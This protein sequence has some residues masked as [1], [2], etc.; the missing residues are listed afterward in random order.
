MRRGNIVAQKQGD[1]FYVLRLADKNVFLQADIGKLLIPHL[2]SLLKD[3]FAGSFCQSLRVID[4]LGYGIAGNAK[5]IR[6][7]L[8]GNFFHPS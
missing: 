4:C 1:F 3:P 5:L 8:N 6:N 7:I 2:D